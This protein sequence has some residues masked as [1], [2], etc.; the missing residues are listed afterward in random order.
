MLKLP[1]SIKTLENSNNASITG[2]PQV[3]VTSLGITQKNDSQTVSPTEEM[4]YS[5]ILTK[6]PRV[7]A[8]PTISSANDGKVSPSISALK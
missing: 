8:I 2:S 4:E 5:E 1:K 7:M 3:L 6:P